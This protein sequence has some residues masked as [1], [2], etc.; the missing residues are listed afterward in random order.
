MLYVILFCFAL[1]SKCNGSNANMIITYFDKGKTQR[2]QLEPSKERQLTKE[3][4]DIFSG[5][6]SELRLYVDSSRVESL[7]ASDKSIEIILNESKTFITEKKG[8]Y[9]LN[10]IIIPLS[11]D[12][13]LNPKLDPFILIKGNDMYSGSPLVVRNKSN[14]LRKLVSFINEYILDNEDK[15]IIE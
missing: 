2:I 7:K 11:G 3:I 1:F 4:E 5:V 15:I 10:R 13:F 8:S 14:Q 6:D 9:K 12:L